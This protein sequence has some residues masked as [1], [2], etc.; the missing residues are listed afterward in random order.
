MPY[1]GWANHATWG[2]ALILDNEEGVQRYF[3]E[4][5]RELAKE[6]PEREEQK[7]WTEEDYVEFTLADE[8]KEQVEQVVN[9]SVEGIDIEFRRL[10]VSQ[11]MQT[12]LGEVNWHEVARHFIEE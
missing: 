5:A 2:T 6:A 1:Q 11:L 9:E 12:A 4:R 7:Y 10:M 8:I 3:F